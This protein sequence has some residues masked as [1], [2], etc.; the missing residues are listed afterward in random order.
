MQCTITLIVYYSHTSTFGCGHVHAYNFITFNNLSAA[1]L[2][3]MYGCCRVVKR[4]S[5]NL[6]SL[7]L[8]GV[9]VGFAGTLLNA[10]E[11]D[12]DLP[13]PLTTAICNVSTMV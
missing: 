13:E 2:C 10:I 3:Y 6:N 12:D 5:L 11:L 8:V 9:F 1:N 4:S 7:I